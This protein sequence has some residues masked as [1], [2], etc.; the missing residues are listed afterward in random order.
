MARSHPVSLS[1]AAALLAAP[2][3]LTAVPVPAAAQAP[4]S[5]GQRFNRF[6]DAEFDQYLVE[7]PQAATQLG[8]KVGYD[9]LNDVSEA[10]EL[11]DLTWRRASVARMKAQFKREA[12]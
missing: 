3:A 10:A 2:L 5:E 7:N 12:L 1:L 11:K 8:S 4:A 9:R 6:L